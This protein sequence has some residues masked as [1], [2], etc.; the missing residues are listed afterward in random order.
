MTDFSGQSSY[1]ALPYVFEVFIYEYASR[2]NRA[3]DTKFWFE[4]RTFLSDLAFFFAPWPYRGIWFNE[5]LCCPKGL[6]SNIR[7]GDPRNTLDAAA[8]CYILRARPAWNEFQ[9]A[10]R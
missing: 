9:L 10:R 6:G 1:S 7:L 8:D 3:F 2:Y 4:L 5:P